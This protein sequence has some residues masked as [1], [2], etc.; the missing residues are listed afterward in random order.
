MQKI[1]LSMAWGR[2]CRATMEIIEQGDA[3]KDLDITQNINIIESLKSEM[4]YK[5]ADVFQ[6]HSEDGAHLDKDKNIADLI[7]LLYLLASKMG[8][9]YEAIDKMVLSRLLSGIVSD[10][11]MWRSDLSAL[12]QH[13]EQ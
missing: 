10:E 8:Y 13:L 6:I 9:S 1:R 12:K 7:I 11:G 4:L 3:M 2:S 5:V